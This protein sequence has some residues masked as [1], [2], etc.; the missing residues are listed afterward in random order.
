MTD[1]PWLIVPVETKVRELDAKVLF[2]SAAAEAGWRVLLG[3]QNAL[4]QRLPFL[5]RGYYLDKSTARSKVKYFDRMHRLG[6]GIL[7]WCEE[8]LVYRDRDAYLHERIA[9]DA[10]RRAERFFTWGQNQR[11]DIMTVLP[12]EGGRMTVAGNPR[13]DLLRAELRDFYR[14]DAEQVR[15]RYGRNIL[16][17]TNFGRYNH[18]F[19]VDGVRQILHKRG[20]TDSPEQTT[21]YEGWIEF[22]GQVFHSFADMLPQLSAAMPD[23]TIIVR[24]HP[25][26]N[27][28]TWREIARDLPNVRVVYEGNIIPW[29][30]ATDAVIHNS[31][32]TGLEAALLDIPVLAYRAARSDVY[33][34][35]LPNRVSINADTPDELLEALRDVIDGKRPMPINDAEIRAEVRRFVASID[36]ATATDRIVE[37]LAPLRDAPQKPL[38]AGQ[39]YA[40]I[41]DGAEQAARGAARRVLAPL[42]SSSG[43]ARQKFS[44]FDTVEIEER[45][46]RFQALTGRFGA[47]AIRRHGRGACVVETRR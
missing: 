19:G 39:T 16:V 10:F 22:L 28:G 21:F 24:P 25:S 40:S 1:K 46:A 20:I 45:V 27:H 8:G 6:F 3:E 33:D 23:H 26:E 18:Y 7:A 15:A 11:D 31:C 9:P 37:A 47:V 4:L 44:G 41:R 2:A 29:L 35:Y 34:S 38:T 30:L 12:G 42:R 14:A 36:G 43:Y 17:N 13:F 32:T 5:P